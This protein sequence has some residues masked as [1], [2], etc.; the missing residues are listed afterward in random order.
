MA[1]NNVRCTA[2]AHALLLQAFIQCRDA[3]MMHTRKKTY[4][5]N[6]DK[7]VVILFVAMLCNECKVKRIASGPK[8]SLNEIFFF[9][10]KCEMSVRIE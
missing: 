9:R 7:I 4:M 8:N 6:V 10:I 5:C 1:K 2:L 3:Y